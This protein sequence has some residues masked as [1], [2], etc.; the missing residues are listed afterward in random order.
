[1]KKIL[2]IFFVV[3]AFLT[4]SIYY[5][6]EK[7]ISESSEFNGQKLL[8]KS[9]AFHD[10]NNLWPKF[11]G[12]LNVTMTR[13]N[14]HK[15][16][17]VVKINLP[18]SFFELTINEGKNIIEKIVNKQDCIV[19][20]NGKNSYSDNQIKTHKLTC[21]NAKKMRDY[22]TY[23]YGLPMKLKDSGTIIHPKV[24]NRKF[25]GKNYLVLKVDY[26]EPVGKDRWYFYFNPETYALE[27]YQFFHEESKNDGEYI[28]LSEQIEISGIIMPKVRSWFYNEQEKYLGTDTLIG[29]L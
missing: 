16:I 15:R 21:K 12:V 28:L 26:S 6:G 23:L 9:I 29:K 14:G 2:I 5:V 13:P 3:L 18:K 20:L 11:N 7:S 22:Y 8:E 4:L 1:M 25:K 10:P 24:E 17:S 27:A 19:K